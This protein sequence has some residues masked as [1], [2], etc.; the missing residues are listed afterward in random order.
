MGHA[1]VLCLLLGICV[2]PSHLASAGK[3]GTQGLNERCLKETTVEGC[4]TI[5]LSWSYSNETSKCEKGFVCHECVN[6]FDTHDE[7]TTTCPM[8]PT[9][10]AKP[11]LVRKQK[12]RNCR[13]WLMRGG[14]CQ[15]IWFEFEKNKLGVMRRLLYYTGCRQDKNR[16]FEYDFYRKKCHEVKNRPSERTQQKG[17]KDGAKRRGRKPTSSGEPNRTTYE[18]ADQGPRA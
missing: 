9:Q 18:V 16:L 13:F 3:T 17:G 8:L 5:L 1:D 11:K 12:R 2:I 10:A 4:E 6:R 14:S 7:C 15:D